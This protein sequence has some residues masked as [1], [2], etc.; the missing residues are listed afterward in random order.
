M[1]RRAV[2]EDFEPDFGQ[3]VIDEVKR[4]KKLYCAELKQK[5]EDKEAERRR[6]FA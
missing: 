3:P 6:A 4:L 2:F 5:K 1:A